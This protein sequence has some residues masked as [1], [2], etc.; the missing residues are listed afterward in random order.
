LSHPARPLIA[1]WPLGTCRY[2]LVD[3]AVGDDKRVGYIDAA[4]GS[5]LTVGNEPKKTLS[6]LISILPQIGFGRTA[7]VLIKTRAAAASYGEALN[8]AG[9]AGYTTLLV[10]GSTDLTNDA[11]DRVTCGFRTAVAGPNGNTSFTCAGGATSTVFSVAAGGIGAEPA[12]LQFRVRFAANTATAA[13]RNVCRN[14]AAHTNTQITL[15]LNLPAAPA[16]TDT[17][18]IEG[19]GVTVTGIVTAGGGETASFRPN[20]TLVGVRATSTT[21]GDVAF[22]GPAL[23]LAGIELSGVT[24]NDVA[25]AQDLRSLYWSDDYID[26]AG[27]TRTIGVGGRS[28]SPVLFSVI[29]QIRGTS[30]GFLNGATSAGAAFLS[31]VI[32]G[33]FG[34]RSYFE[35]GVNLTACGQSASEA[36][37]AGLGVGGLLLGTNNLGSTTETAMRVENLA[38]SAG[39]VVIASS[40]LTLLRLAFKNMGGAPC[41]FVRG[42]CGGII[43]IDGC[44]GSTGNTGVG[45]KVQTL[46]NVRSAGITLLLGTMEANTFGGTVGEISTVES[47]VFTHATLD[48]T[49]VVDTDGNNYIGSARAVVPVGSSSLYTNGDGTA[50]GVGEVVRVSAANTVVRAKADTSA[51]VDGPLLVCLTTP[52]SGDPGLFVSMGTPQKWVLH[53]AAP[54][55]MGLSYVSPGTGGKATTTVPVAAATNQK[56]RLGHVAKASGNFGLVVGSPEL[57]QIAADGS[58]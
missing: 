28:L 45:L 21:T 18:F 24:N 1:D 33:E 47:A 30:L 17:F 41:V 32:G 42:S 44:T 40:S 35:S 7:V 29:Q 31:R 54:A 46:G 57:L 19:P 38:G 50:L 52:A 11:A 53:D 2:F 10:R 5:T 22:R 13:L 12:G 23:G 16:N 14:I 48:T 26:E 56:R 34:R 8:L 27:T 6:G 51:H 15:G 37:A 36:Q 4:P 49:N 20:V 39:G 3:F 25:N 58:A 9:V 43:I 55:L